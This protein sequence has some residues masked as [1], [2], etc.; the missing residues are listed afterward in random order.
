MV[1]LMACEARLQYWIQNPVATT[2]RVTGHVA[3]RMQNH[4]GS[5]SSLQAMCRQL[6]QSRKEGTLEL[7][8]DFKIVRAEE[9]ARIMVYW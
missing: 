3:I 1:E 9:T 6:S 4:T 5:M 2:G 7:F 8:V